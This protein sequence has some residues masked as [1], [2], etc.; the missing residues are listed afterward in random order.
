MSDPKV[1]KATHLEGKLPP[2]GRAILRGFSEERIAKALAAMRPPS[3]I[4]TVDALRLTKASPLSFVRGL[5][6]RMCDK[7]WDIERVHRDINAEGAGFVVYRVRAEGRILTF[8]TRSTGLEPVERSGRIKDNDLDFHAG[9]FDGEISFERIKAESDE[10]LAKVWRGRTDNLSLGWTFA[11]R[12]NRSFDYTIDALSRGEQPDVRVLAANGGYIIRN[13]GFYGNGRHGCRSWQSFST[14]HP[15]S[16]PYHV[17]LFCLY[18]WR[19]VGFD[20][21]EAIAR[22]RNP[23]AAALDPEIKRYVGVGNS[24]GI[25]MVAAL[26]RWPH[27]VSGFCYAREF[28]LAMALTEDGPPPSAQL[29]ALMRLLDRAHHYYGENDP[30]IDPIVEDRPRIAKELLA[31]KELAR[32][33]RDRGT[34]G[35]VPG[36]PQLQHLMSAVRARFLPNTAA[37]FAALVI[38]TRPD[39]VKRIRPLQPAAMASRRNTVPDMSLGELQKLIERDYDWALKIDFRR[40]GAR[41]YF[42]YR[43]EENGENRRG[44]REIDPGL[45][46]ETFV[47]VAGSVQALH[48]RIAARPPHWTVARYLVDAPDDIYLVSRVQFLA[49]LPYGEIR[50]NLIDAAFRPSD[51]I[52]FY[53]SVL[54]METTDPGNYRWVRGVFMQGAPLPEDLLHGE[55]R[56]W[57]LPNCPEPSAD[58]RQT[59]EA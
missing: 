1:P 46:Y 19:L 31:V 45:D 32:E 56:D 9:L 26:V 47:D 13:A 40:P 8:A 5:I 12:S 33:L 51:M 55:H 50:S 22:T 21:V 30:G 14:N 38:E 58:L 7:H 39:L 25:G 10:Q 34:V 28:A 23:Q 35:G 16:D 29:D 37:Q 27:W 24:S 11:N 43:S 4:M 6:D 41:R 42:W 2:Y 54:G 44:E 53:L 15:L 59:I 36:K 57:S 48:A 49:D 3:E 52:Q 17:D 20:L 18:L